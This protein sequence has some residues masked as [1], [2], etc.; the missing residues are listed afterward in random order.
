LKHLRRELEE[1]MKGE[2][3]GGEG[4]GSEVGRPWPTVS[5]CSSTVINIR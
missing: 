4:K 5:C 2:R 3:T 1:L